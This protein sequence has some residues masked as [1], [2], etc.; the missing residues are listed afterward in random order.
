MIDIGAPQLTVWGASHGLIVLG[1]IRKL[2]ESA[3][4]EQVSKQ[5]SSTASVAAPHSRFCFEFLSRL[6][7]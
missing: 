5:P 7:Q 4:E 2:S 3:M 1:A 6:P